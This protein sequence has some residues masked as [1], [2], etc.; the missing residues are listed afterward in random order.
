MTGDAWDLLVVGGGTAGIVGATTAAGL[1]AR[2]LLVEETRTGGDCLWTGCVPSK[3]LLAA[4]GAAA[5]ARAAAGFGVDVGEVRVDFDR[6]RSHVRAAI[7]AIEPEDSPETLRRAGIVV[8]SGTVVLTGPDTAR[9]GDRDLRFR[10]ALL[11]TGSSPASPPVAGL[12]DARPLTTET[13][14]DLAELPGRLVVLGGGTIGCE[15]GQAFA[16]LGSAVT[17]VDGADRLLPDEDGEASAI[18]TAALRRDGADVRTGS[19]AT[20]VRAGAVELGSGDAL[21]YDV[22]LVALGR[23]PRT[24]GLGC[25]AAGVELA[26]D[27]SVVVDDRLRTSNPRIVAAG[28]VTDRS[29]FTHTAGVHASLAV[30]NVLLGRGRTIDP[31]VPRVTYTSPEVAAVGAPPADADAHGWTTRRIPHSTV[32]RAVT[33]RTTEGYTTLVLDR[34]RRIVGATVVGPRAGETLGELALAVRA[35]LTAGDLT[36]TTHPYPTFNDGAWN[37]AIAATRGRLAAPPARA[38]IGAAMGLRRWWLDRHP[39]GRE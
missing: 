8:E 14:W 22:L 25:A 34:R 17:I 35:G 39:P 23:R 27:G 19:P 1:G 30:S 5:S 21:P 28:D 7:T 3:A 24:A 2:V 15:L 9:V 31:V 29:R 18:V 10:A 38:L 4:A 11:A 12:A 13:V 36:G 32:H 6:V 33:E 20:R 37:A 16:R 26:G